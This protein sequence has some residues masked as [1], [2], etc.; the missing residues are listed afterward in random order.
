MNAQFQ[1]AMPQAL[2]LQSNARV[3]RLLQLAKDRKCH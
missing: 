3:Q 2:Q 1:Q